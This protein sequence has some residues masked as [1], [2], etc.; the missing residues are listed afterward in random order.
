MKQRARIMVKVLLFLL[1]GAIINVAVAW[2]CARGLR[3]GIGVTKRIDVTFDEKIGTITTVL[4]HK[5]G[6]PCRTATLNCRRPFKTWLDSFS[7]DPSVT[8]LLTR[9]SML[10][11]CGCS[12]QFRVWRGGGFASSAAGVP[13]VRIQWVT[14]PFALS[15]ARRHANCRFSNDSCDSQV[16]G[17][18]QDPHQSAAPGITRNT[19]GAPRHS[20]ALAHTTARRSDAANACTTRRSTAD[21]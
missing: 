10:R 8:A 1:A 4:D 19:I 12:S 21:G 11:L 6:W 13:G 20:A 18:G 3:D 16:K 14:V 15:A 17:Y 7:D 2:A 9:S 5:V